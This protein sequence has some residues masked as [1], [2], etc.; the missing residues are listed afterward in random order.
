MKTIILNFENC[1]RLS[2]IHKTLKTAFE[3]PD[4]YGNN[5]DALWDCLNGWFIGEGTVIVE[6]RGIG[7]L[8]YDLRDSVESMFSVFKD[9]SIDDPNV[10]FVIV[11]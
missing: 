5:W 8:K 2:E 6:I 1:R 3:L 9:V 7:S 10:K 11:S 4:Y